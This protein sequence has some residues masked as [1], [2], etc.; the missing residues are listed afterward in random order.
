MHAKSCLLVVLGT[1]A[2][3]TA[4]RGGTLT[5]TYVGD[6]AGVSVGVHHDATAAWDAAPSTSFASPA[7]AGARNFQSAG[8]S[9]R[10]FATRFAQSFAVGEVLAYAQVDPDELPGGDPTFT[11]IG[12]L[13]ADLL[14][15]LYGRYQ[16]HVTT[17]A[18]PTLVAG[19]QLAVWEILHEN[20]TVL[21]RSDAASRLSLDLGAFQMD[22]A[23]GP[24]AFVAY[25]HANM[26][27][28]SL[29]DGPFATMT[30]LR[31]WT[32]GGSRDQLA[33]SV[34]PLP[35]PALLAAAGLLV[36]GSRR[37]SR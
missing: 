15:D 20:L 11:P 8:R 4:A 23:S 37:R 18:D 7:F 2:A 24:D 32:D 3:S 34:V 25:V 29:I 19:F 27:L 36:A 12:R 13:R 9:F 14:A 30:S 17:D 21:D 22:A 16:G 5:M 35:A 10:T 26:M 33:S 31:G 6:A 1:A 28:A